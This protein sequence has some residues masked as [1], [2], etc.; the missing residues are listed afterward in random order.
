MSKMGGGGGGVAERSLSLW[1][2]LIKA[3]EYEE[4]SG[5]VEGRLRG[6][7]GRPELVENSWRWLLYSIADDQRFGRGPLGSPSGACDVALGWMLLKSRTEDAL[8]P[9]IEGAT[10]GALE[11][12]L[13]LVLLLLPSSR[14][15]Y[16]WLMY[17]DDILVPVPACPWLKSST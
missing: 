4:L 10:E 2:D 5:L 15:P 12:A 6:I 16:L 3:S 17:R 13:E 9:A 8:D 1:E 7:G 14:S 11:V